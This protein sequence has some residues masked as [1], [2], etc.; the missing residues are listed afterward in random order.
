MAHPHPHTTVWL[1]KNYSQHILTY[2]TRNV[3]D[4]TYG[5]TMLQT[6]ERDLL[7]Q[8]FRMLDVRE[9]RDSRTVCVTVPLLR[10]R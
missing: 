3:L 10:Y 7:R 6:N 8:R 4:L 1:L 5:R 9:R 2:C